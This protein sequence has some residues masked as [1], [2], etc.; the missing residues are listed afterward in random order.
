MEELLVKTFAIVMAIVVAAMAIF[1]PLIIV[2]A[3][4][5]QRPAK[6]VAKAIEHVSAEARRVY[7][8]AKTELTKLGESINE[9]IVVVKSESEV[10]SGLPK[11]DENSTRLAGF[12]K[13]NK[14]A[15]V[16]IDFSTIPAGLKEM[17]SRHIL[18]G[19]LRFIVEMFERPHM[20]SFWSAVDT[21]KEVAKAI[22]TNDVHMFFAYTEKKLVEGENKIVYEPRYLYFNGFQFIGFHPSDEGVK[23]VIYKAF[24]AAYNPPTIE[25]KL[26]GVLASDTDVTELWTQ[27]ALCS[28]PFDAEVTVWDWK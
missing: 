19:C 8:A 7:K 25:V 20:P 28:Y 1:H 4:N 11:Y 12:I 9:E 21:Y 3:L 13:S 2:Y 14:P 22:A 6:K 17:L 10:T 15:D 27:D 16:E 23:A 24:L 26:E 5:H 18:A